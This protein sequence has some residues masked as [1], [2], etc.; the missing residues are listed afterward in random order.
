MNNIKKS[1]E[2]RNEVIK[3]INEK[4]GID[5]IYSYNDLYKIKMVY[6]RRLKG[7]LYKRGEDRYY[8]LIDSNSIKIEEFN[9]LVLEID[10]FVKE[11]KFE[12]F[13]IR[14]K[15]V[16]NCVDERDRNRYEERNNEFISLKEFREIVM[17]N[18]KELI[19]SI[20]FKNN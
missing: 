6:S 15:K 8:Y 2:V 9:N 19:L 20:K 17:K 10:N 3:L 4:F 14:L 16:V 13:E 5:F 11:L 12:G 7:Y 18:E 1:L